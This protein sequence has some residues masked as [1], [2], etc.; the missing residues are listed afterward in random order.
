MVSHDRGSY[1]DDVYD[2]FCMLRLDTNLWVGVVRTL[3]VH[4][5]TH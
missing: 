3:L 5:K 2:I 4:L 1:L